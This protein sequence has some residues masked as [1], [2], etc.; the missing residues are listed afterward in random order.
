MTESNYKIRYKKGDFELEIQGDKE[1]VE[2][3]LKEL[4]ESEMVAS[5]VL[6]SKTKTISGSLVEFLKSKGNPRSHTDKA[7]IFSYWLFHKE[8]MNCYNID[9][10]EKCYDEARITKPKN[11]TDV[12]NKIQKKGYVKPVPKEKNGKK[13]W[14]ITQTGEEYVEKMK[15]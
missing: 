1:W 9:D 11:I 8:K 10:I 4:T 15:G 3:K 6:T 14:I 2:Q 13:A 7:T 5:E 12:M